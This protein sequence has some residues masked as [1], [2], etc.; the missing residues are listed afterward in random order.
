MIRSLSGFHF[1]NNAVMDIFVAKSDGSEVD[2]EKRK[3]TRII[4]RFYLSN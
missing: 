2:S 1:I 4:S 3:K